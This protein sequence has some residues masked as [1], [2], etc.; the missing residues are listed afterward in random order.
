MLAV[1]NIPCTA[2]SSYGSANDSLLE[3]SKWHARA[4]RGIYIYAYDHIKKAP[5]A[6]NVEADWRKTTF[7]E[8]DSP[9]LKSPLGVC[10]FQS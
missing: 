2:R 4:D 1:F 8:F 5:T 9:L 6:Q 3:A 7:G 10:Q